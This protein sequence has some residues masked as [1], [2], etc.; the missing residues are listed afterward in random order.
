MPQ[1]HLEEAINA[2]G[3]PIRLWVEACRELEICPQH[4]EEFSPKTP[5]EPRVSIAHNAPWNSPKLHNV[6]D[7]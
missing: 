2:L 3:L 5:S 1:V 4:L 7:E 6:L